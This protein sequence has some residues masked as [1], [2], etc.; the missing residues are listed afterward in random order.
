MNDK[1]IAL[2]ASAHGGIALSSLLAVMKFYDALDYLATDGR[3]VETLSLGI[4]EATRLQLAAAWIAAVVSLVGLVLAVLASRKS[5]EA[6]RPARRLAVAGLAVAG[7]VASVVLVLGTL[8]YVFNRVLIPAGAS[9]VSCPTPEEISTRLLGAAIGSAIFVLLAVALVIASMRSAAAP[10][11]AV[12][13]LA[14][15]L[16]VSVAMIASLR[17]YS[18]HYEAIA[19]PSALRA[20]LRPR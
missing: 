10:S 12:V 17:A 20:G 19:G 3:G 14:A 15:S 4:V 16:L 8:A 9:V 13:V 5:V 2:V 7:G 1:T 6:G 11:V 18:N